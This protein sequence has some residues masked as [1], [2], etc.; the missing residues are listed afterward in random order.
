MFYG[1]MYLLILTNG[2]NDAHGTM[3]VIIYYLY[4]GEV[5][6][7]RIFFHD[8]IKFSD[9]HLLSNFST[10]IFIYRTYFNMK[11]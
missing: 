10:L 7:F 4:L 8:S 2:V 11:L 5:T 6:M 1:A 3:I 9:T